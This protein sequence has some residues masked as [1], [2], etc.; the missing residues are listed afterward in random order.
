MQP[1][2]RMYFITI[3]IP[4]R[5]RTRRR[6]IR[7]TS[8]AALRTRSLERCI[9]PDC[10]GIDIVAV[11]NNKPS[12]CEVSRTF[13]Y[14]TSI[15]AS[16]LAVTRRLSFS[17]SLAFLSRYPFRK[18]KTPGRGQRQIENFTGVTFDP[19]QPTPVQRSRSLIS[20]FLSFPFLSLLSSFFPFVR[21]FDIP[22]Q[23][24]YL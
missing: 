12:Q 19:G 2:K 17:S 7:T 24:Y 14:G 4:S 8:S 5:V 11:S 23:L 13:G 10:P 6:Y 21:F 9:V 1:R 18:V 15:C 3:L 20:F 16:L 22:V